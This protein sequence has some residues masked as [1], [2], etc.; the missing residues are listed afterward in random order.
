MAFQYWKTLEKN[1]W[2]YLLVVSGDTDEE[3]ISTCAYYGAK[4]FLKKPISLEEFKDII[5][6]IEE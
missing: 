1:G 6:V 4:A 2:A 3:T 5:R